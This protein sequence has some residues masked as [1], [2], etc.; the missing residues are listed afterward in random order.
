MLLKGTTANLFWN[1]PIQAK[2]F[3]TEPQYYIS[4]LQPASMM[5]VDGTLSTSD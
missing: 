4:L 2:S 5:A 1:F 3:Y